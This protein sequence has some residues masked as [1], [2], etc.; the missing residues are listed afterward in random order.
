VSF[1]IQ[2]LK[3]RKC[4]IEL[5]R[6]IS[7]T[8]EIEKGVPQ[9]SC[10][11]PILFLLFHSELIHRIPSATH[12]H[13]FANDLALIINASP[14]WH[15]SK[16]ASQMQRIG[17]QALNQVQA[18]AVEWK[19]P[20]NFSKT[21]WQWIHRRVFIPPLSLAKSVNIPSREQLFSNTLAITLMNVSYSINIARECFKRSRKTLE[22]SNM[23]LDRKHHQRERENSSLTR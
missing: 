20:I 3:N 6:T 5:N 18:Y 11:G 13:L 7:N 19:Q 10:L 2:Y 8:F 4:Y 16:F 12:A 22:F 1:I 9:G 23:L 14:W 21:E 15:P 17:Q